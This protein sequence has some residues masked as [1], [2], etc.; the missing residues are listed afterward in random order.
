M[1]ISATHESIPETFCDTAEK[2][3]K[4]TTSRLQRV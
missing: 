2:A 1:T 4:S 3:T